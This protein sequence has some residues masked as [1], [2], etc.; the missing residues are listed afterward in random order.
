MSEE[1]LINV[2][3]RET[4][5]AHVENG[6]L[7][8]VFIER[9]KRRGLVGNV[10]KG[11]IQRVMPGMQAAFV[12]L[13]LERTAFLHASDIL[14]GSLESEILDGVTNTSANL[15]IE[16]LVREGQEVI[17]Q[18]VKDPIGS[19][20]ARLS[21]HLSIPSR[22]LVLLPNTK[23]TGVSARIEDDL[24]RTRLK[25]IMADVASASTHG[26]IVRTNAEGAGE[27]ALRA[28]VAYLEKLWISLSASLQPSKVGTRIYED[29]PLFLRVLRDMRKS[30]IEKVRIDSRETI[31][32]AEK[33]TEQFVPELA[34]C[35]EHYPG[36]RP[37]FDLYGVEDEIQRALGKNAQLK[38]GG[39]LV[40]QQTE[41]M[42][43]VDVNTGG[44]LGTRNLEDTVYKTNLEAAQAIARQ[45]R[46]RNL[47]GII[48]IDFIDM[49]DVEH[50][51]QVMRTLEK[52]LA[53][54]HAKTTVY[55]MSPLGLV[56]MTRKRTTESL[57]RQL[58]DPC[59]ACSG[60]GTVKSVETMVYEVFREITRSV[61]QFEAESL[62]VVAA[63]DVVNRI[64]DDESAALAELELFIG[65]TIRF[66]AEEQYPPE[67]YDVVLL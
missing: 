35:I 12:E 21:T 45:L 4:R 28:D 41:A 32:R 48:I 8:E 26:F 65:K 3:P 16:Q 58:C 22:Y 1:I 60:R 51:K 2:T 7:Q 47:G 50:R 23:M 53:K 9:A 6:M 54:D 62:L 11:R 61:R 36:E 38:S 49:H 15:S 39:H 25:V 27:E 30:H 10:Y 64:I 24:E 57:E 59:S 56:E 67:Q 18:V 42:I 33:F 44:F 31:E 37:I 52:A 13:G 46:L 17:V 20:G 29:L 5:V 43:T 55:E 19:K 14:R 34:N 66:K 40:I 63:T